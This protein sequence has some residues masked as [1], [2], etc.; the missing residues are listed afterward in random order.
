MAGEMKRP[1][2]W[3]STQEKLAL[4]LVGRELGDAGK[5]AQW[6]AQWATRSASETVATNGSWVKE[7]GAKELTEGIQLTNLH[8]S[9][10]FV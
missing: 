9:R 3:Y 6:R 10:L 5:N 8:G 1:E 7:I 4:F 2:H